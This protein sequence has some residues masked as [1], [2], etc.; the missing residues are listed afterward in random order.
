MPKLK[1]RTWRNVKLTPIQYEML[2]DAICGFNP[3]RVKPEHHSVLDALL[4]HGLLREGPSPNG[5]YELPGIRCAWR[6]ERSC[7]RT[8]GQAQNR[9]RWRL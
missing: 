5:E 9:G 3:I 2:N 6:T 1:E 4:E 8:A 7:Q